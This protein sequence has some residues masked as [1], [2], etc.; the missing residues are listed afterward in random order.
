MWA[1]SYIGSNLGSMALAMHN[2]KKKTIRGGGST[3]LYAAYTV[4]LVC[5]VDMVYPV[6]MVYTVGMVYTVDMICTVGIWTWGLRGLRGEKWIH[7]GKD[8]AAG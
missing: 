8:R 4:D 2:Y 7:C 3:A 1:G 6:D 5:T